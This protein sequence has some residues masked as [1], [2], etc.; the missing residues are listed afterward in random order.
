M[1]I[2]AENP[3]NLAALG[4]LFCQLNFTLHSYSKIY[5]YANSK[6]R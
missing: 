4:W 6:K 3:G 5:Q 1:A 2:Y